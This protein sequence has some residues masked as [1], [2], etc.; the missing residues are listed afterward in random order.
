MIKPLRNRRRDGRIYTRMTHVEGLLQ[1]LDA[2]PP[3][4]L[5]DRCRLPKIDEKHVPTECV[6]HFVRRAWAENDLALCELLFKELADRVRRFLPKTRRDKDV[7]YIELQINEEVFDKFVEMLFAEREGYDERLDFFEV[8]FLRGLASLRSTARERAW[9]EDNSKQGLFSEENE[10]ELE[11]EVD[12]LTA[13]DP[14]APDVWDQPFYRTRL[15]RAIGKLNPL[16]KRIIEM[17]RLEIPIES[18]NAT[19]VSMVKVL[20]MSEK[21]I[22]NRRDRA[23]AR[24]RR[25]LERGE[26]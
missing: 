9:A 4:E 18:K 13:Y 26:L 22:R 2:L 14:F 7:P 15:A 17:H 5:I 10:G 19:V 6:V 24:L 16:D 3:Q 21:G 20:G 1:T 12:S 11:V 25:E 8:F 23:L